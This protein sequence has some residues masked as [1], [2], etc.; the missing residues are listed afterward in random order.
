ME[1]HEML[2]LQLWM[3]AKETLK[4]LMAGSSFIFRERMLHAAPRSRLLSKHPASEER[5]KIFD[6]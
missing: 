6:I 5:V 3:P 1:R 2:S 4:L